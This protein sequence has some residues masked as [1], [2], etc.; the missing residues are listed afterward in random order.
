MEHHN[1][2]NEYK[3]GKKITEVTTEL[4]KDRFRNILGE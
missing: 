4:Q 1:V 3:N 2:C